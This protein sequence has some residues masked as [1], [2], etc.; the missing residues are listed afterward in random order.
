MAHVVAV[1]VLDGTHPFEFAVA[2]E[3]FGLE[4]PELPGEPY[5]LRLCTPNR[6]VALQGGAQLR[7]THGLDALV[8]ADTI[9]VPHGPVDDDP[10]V[11]VVRAL[12]Q[13]HERGAR[14]V[15]FCSGAFVLA[16]T[17]LLDGRRATTH[18]MH[19]E[20]FRRRH[21]RVRMDANVLFVDEG[22]LLT[23]AGTAAAI[24]LCLHIVRRDHG[25]EAAR[26]VARR[27]VV[28]PH[29]DG[30]QA[31]FIAPVHEP[32]VQGDELA[33]LLEWLVANVHREVTVA[34]MADRA[35]MSER[36]FARRFKEVTG[37]TPFR[38]LLAQRLQRAQALLETTDLDVERVA[39]RVGLGSAA[40]LR[41][42]FRRELATTPSAYRRT[43]SVKR[44][45]AT[46]GS[47]PRG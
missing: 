29:R 11:R 18:W 36:T 30:G 37:T 6:G 14:L 44:G 45:G 22:A 46:A 15:S 8:H 28:A 41:E 27:M 10:D 19:A 1:V 21:P 7:G 4:R 40:N 35:A 2:C 13:G 3:V 26:T 24:D 38:W 17:G 47:V 25:A 32:R 5:E 33:D 31:Q 34:E 43:F 9:V 23:S 42:H 39:R 20:S 12:V 16:A